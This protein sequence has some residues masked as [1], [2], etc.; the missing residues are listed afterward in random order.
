V[1]ELGASGR[2]EGLEALAEG[3]LH[4]LERHDEER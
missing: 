1:E 2:R 4:L 3:L